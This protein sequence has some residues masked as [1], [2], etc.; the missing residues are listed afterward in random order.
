M[1]DVHIV[2]GCLALGLNLLAFLLGTFAWVR[3]RPN[4]WFWRLLRGGQV[5]VA[6][7]AALGGILLLM[8]RKA[9]N[10]HLLYGVLPL[11][12]ALIAEQLK[13]SAA[14]MVLDARGLEDAKAVAQLPKDDQRQIV[15]S[16]MR[17]E[18]GVMT[19]SAVVVTALLARAATVVH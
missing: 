8:G 10:L 7:E 12:V 1:K 13:L 16:I 2:V 11:V 6:V 3:S 4:A 18:I 19:L 5:M 17:R 9:S 15:I 14:T